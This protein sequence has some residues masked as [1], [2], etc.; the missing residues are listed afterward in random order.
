MKQFS[1][2][3]VDDTVSRKNITYAVCFFV[4]SDLSFRVS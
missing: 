2:R 3:L 1:N 4:S